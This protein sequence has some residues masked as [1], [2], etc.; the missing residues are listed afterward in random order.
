MI[1]DIQ[2]KIEIHMA[3]LRAELCTA[4]HQSSSIG[5]TCCNVAAL[6][7]EIFAYSIGLS[8][9][10]SIDTRVPNSYLFIVEPSVMTVPHG[11]K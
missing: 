11:K 6:Q 1:D 4:E 2:V 3:T 10:F 9:V 8:D 7:N 5:S